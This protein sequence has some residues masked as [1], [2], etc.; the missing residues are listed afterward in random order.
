MSKQELRDAVEQFAKDEVDVSRIEEEE[1]LLLEPLVDEVLQSLQHL[2]VGEQSTGTV[3]DTQKN[4]VVTQL[5]VKRAF[6]RYYH[7][8]LSGARRRDDIGTYSTHHL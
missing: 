3:Q 2:N 6:E 7:S 8:T 1:K 5:E 4:P